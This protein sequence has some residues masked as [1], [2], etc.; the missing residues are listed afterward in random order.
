M[1]SVSLIILPVDDKTKSFAKQPFYS[2]NK[3][4]KKNYLKQF[5]GHVNITPG[6]GIVQGCAAYKSYFVDHV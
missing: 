3:D 4:I 2:G 1:T 5:V 6:H